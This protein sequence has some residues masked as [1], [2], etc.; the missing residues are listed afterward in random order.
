MR[1]PITKYGLP[2]V[3]LLPLIISALIA[4]VLAA[5]N[6]LPLWLLW[7]LEAILVILFVF[8]LSF[9]RDPYRL[10]PPDKNLLLS[11]ADGKI[12]DIETVD[13]NSFIDGKAIRIGIFLSVFN[14]HIN[15]SPCDV[16]VAKIIY[17]KGGFKDARDP[18]AGI[19]NE[20]NDLMFDREK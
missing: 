13:E 12:A 7:A 3:A 8:V 10:V 15:R 17:K 4:I 5:K 14:V 1:I 19:F 6:V 18:E 11:P 16:K 20:S 9:F 2:Q